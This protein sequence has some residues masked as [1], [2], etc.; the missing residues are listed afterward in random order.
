MNNPIKV[1]IKNFQSIKDL[2][3]DI[4]GFTC[5]TGKSNIGKSAIVRAITSSLLNEPTVGM[6]RKGTVFSTV[7]MGSKDWEYKWEKGERGV[8][9]YTV[10]GSVLD[11]VGQAQIS[12]VRDAGFFPIKVGSRKVNPWYASQFSPIF[13]LD[14]TGPTVTDFISEVSNL[15]TIQ[16]ALL[17]SS[18]GK[19]KA[20]D[21]SKQKSD[22]MSVVKEHES[23]FSGVDNLKLVA[24]DLD[25]QLVSISSYE[26]KIS[27]FEKLSLTLTKLGD[28]IK[29]LD[30]ISSLSFNDNSRELMDS[31]EHYEKRNFW[32]NS[33]TTAAK[34]ITSIQGGSKF[35][36]ITISDV[37]TSEFNHFSEMIKFTSIEVLK[38]KVELF[39]PI[40]S[41]TDFDDAS[42]KLDYS[43][44]VEKSS[45]CELIKNEE[46]K[47]SRLSSSLVS[48]DPISVHPSD[49]ETLK[50]IS[51]MKMN[52][53]SLLKEID[54][55]ELEHKSVVYEI[56]EVNSELRA[57]PNCPSCGRV[58]NTKH[59][60][61]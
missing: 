47:I 8:N 6:V 24:N 5:I 37:P 10:N 29:P 51:T 2:E 23:K 4:S 9:R 22:E 20:L 46:L 32:H 11:K 21:I 1:K 14:E 27:Y 30:Q 48:C 35:P 7:E 55:L 45:Y 54:Q 40:N 49:I 18:K 59:S 19:K 44:F 33:L 15:Q 38:N 3:F 52:L 26:D 58:S 36:T 43:D 28:S 53:S 41:I 16:N 17:M 13:L 60:H 57:I 56:N 12:Y 50:F 34:R 61:I 25:Q 42:L 39:E 31:Y